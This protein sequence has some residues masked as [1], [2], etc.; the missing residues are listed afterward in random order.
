MPENN[1][2]FLG[3]GSNVGDRYSYLKKGIYLINNHPHI[4]IINESYIYES[5][6]LY[7][8]EQTYYYNMVLQID[9]NLEPLDLL[10]EMKII[11]QKLGRKL[12]KIKNSPRELDI[13]IL[14]MGDTIINTKTLTIPH[15][16]IIERKFVLKPWND[17]AADFIIPEIEKSIK[18]LLD[19][20]KDS[21]L[22]K[23]ILI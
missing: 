12:N 21:S 3:L 9:T 7:N 23:R 22:I 14:A 19:L 13:D 10:R 6:P 15:P 2:I 11:E 4:W 1:Q 20:T 5:P 16:F 18:L 8:I 17:I